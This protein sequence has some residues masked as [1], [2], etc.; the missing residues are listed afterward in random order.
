MPS[1]WTC[2]TFWKWWISNIA[3]GA[4]SVRKL[5][6]MIRSPLQADMVIFPGTYHDEWKRSNTNENFFYWLDYGEGKN[7]STPTCARDRLEREQIRYLSREER[8]NYLATVDKEGKLCWKKNGQRIDTSTRWR[9][10]LK[11][12]VP[13]SEED[14]TPGPPGV[15]VTARPGINSGVSS[16]ESSSSSSTS[17]SEDAEER[18]DRYVNQDLK[19]VKGPRKLVHVSPATILNQLLRTSVRKNTWIFVR[20]ILLSPTSVGV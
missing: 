18:G 16:E 3:M 4:I 1:C 13:V 5:G 11:G 6:S 8:M 15:V 20:G 14:A 2:S 9:D 12:I 19:T 7:V 17:E 10:S